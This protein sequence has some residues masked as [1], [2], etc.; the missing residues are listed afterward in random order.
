M[1]ALG[2]SFIN[3][4]NIS[5]LTGIPIITTRAR[6]SEMYDRGIVAQTQKGLYYIPPREHRA[7]IEK[8]RL[9]AKYEKWKKLGEKHGWHFRYDTTE[10]NGEPQPQDYQQGSPIF[11]ELPF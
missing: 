11:G 7:N 1:Y 6:L 2:E 3:A 4:E 10:K 5:L 8:A 9:E